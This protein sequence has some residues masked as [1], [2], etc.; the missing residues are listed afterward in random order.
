MRL[1]ERV[2]HNREEI[3]ALADRHGARNVRLFGS[4]ARGEDRA[5]SDLD[6]LVEFERGRSLMDQVALMLDLQ[7]LLD[8]QVDVVDLEGLHVSM[9][10]RVLAEAVPL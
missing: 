3:R 7:E 5:E 4:V 9:R 1:S 2:V 8:A 6:L 10:D